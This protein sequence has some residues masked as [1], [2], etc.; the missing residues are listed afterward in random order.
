[1]ADKFV[2]IS[3]V[4]ILPAYS[5]EKIYVYL[6][7]DLTLTRQNLDKDEIIDVVTYPLEVALKMIDEGQITDALTVLALQRAWFFLQENI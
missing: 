7:R 3:Q 6:A 1:M 4:L 5:D 2:E